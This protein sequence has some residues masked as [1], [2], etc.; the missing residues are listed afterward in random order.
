MAKHL[1]LGSGTTPRNPYDHTEIYGIDIAS[2]SKKNF[3][4]EK[5]VEIKKVDL[6]IS[7]IPYPDKFFDSISAFDFLEHIPRLIYLQKKNEPFAHYAFIE[8][9][10]EIHR[11]LK[12]GGRFVAFIPYI[13]SIDTMFSDPTHVNYIASGTH[14]YFCEPPLWAKAYGF[15]GRFKIIRYEPCTQEFED[16]FPLLRK[17]KFLLKKIFNRLRRLHENP[18]VT[19]THLLWEF[20]AV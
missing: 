11:T 13:H 15:N 1:D 3:K 2:I 8:L 14:Q 7:K 17:N 20:E 10:N 4:N 18:N 12:K 6:S 9:M 16:L 19:K 5:I